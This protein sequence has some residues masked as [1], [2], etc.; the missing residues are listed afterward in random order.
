METNAI[1]FLSAIAYLI[2]VISTFA[3]GLAISSLALEQDGEDPENLDLLWIMACAVFWPIFHV[4][5][6]MVFITINVTG[7]GAE[8]KDKTSPK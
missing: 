8:S 6:T 7:F 2:M 1:Y 3:Q 4:Y 5:S